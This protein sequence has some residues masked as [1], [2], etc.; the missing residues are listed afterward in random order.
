[1]RLAIELQLASPHL[2]TYAYAANIMALR[3]PNATHLFGGEVRF[4]TNYME[5]NGDIAN[6][7]FLNKV[8]PAYNELTYTSTVVATSTSLTLY[9]YNNGT[10][11]IRKVVGP[12]T[13]I[14][15]SGVW[16]SPGLPQTNAYEIRSTATELGRTNGGYFNRDSYATIGSILDV[17]SVYADQA[18]PGQSNFSEYFFEIY[19][20]KIGQ[21][22]PVQASS[23]TL[24]ALSFAFN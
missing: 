13:D 1:M 16:F 6:I 9:Y 7:V 3:F 19:L 24:Y 14:V 23:V 17:C 21:S 22:S 12:S 2:V 18:Q 15:E 8:V 5:D 20:R 4:N 11:D 10:W